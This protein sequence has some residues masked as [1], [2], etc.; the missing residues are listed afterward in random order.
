MDPNELEEVESDNE[1]NDFIDTILELSRKY[2]DKQI[3]DM[4]KLD[5]IESMLHHLG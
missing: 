1:E 5:Q 3:E 4:N 2:K